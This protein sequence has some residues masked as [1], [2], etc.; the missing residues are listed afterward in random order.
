MELPVEQIEAGTGLSVEDFL[1]RT[2]AANIVLSG[3]KGML[4]RYL[5]P[6]MIL[7]LGDDGQC[8]RSALKIHEYNPPCSKPAKM[9]L[10]SFTH[11]EIAY[12][13]HNYAA[14]KERFKAAAGNKRGWLGSVYA[15]GCIAVG[16]SV[17]TRS[18]ILG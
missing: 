12:E 11:L 7:G 17:F 15:A 16:D 14:I 8:P 4:N 18:P 2:V 9:L 1:A 13:D 5:Q 6:G 3:L 10:D